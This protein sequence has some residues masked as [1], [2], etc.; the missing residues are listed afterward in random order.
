MFDLIVFCVGKESLCEFPKNTN[1]Y[2]EKE[3]RY[4]DIWR[5][6]TQQ[7]GGWYSLFTDDYE[8]A[9][10][11]ICEHLGYSNSIVF[12]EIDSEINVCISPYKIR[13]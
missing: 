8:M 6:L 4:C 2:I 5:F 1:I 9:G 3:Q 12:P 11:D 10:T 13:Q 7:S